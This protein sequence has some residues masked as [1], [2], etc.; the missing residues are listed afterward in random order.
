MI[1]REQNGRRYP[2][3]EY[4]KHKGYLWPA[5]DRFCWPVVFNTVSD[6]E[7]AIALTPGRKVAVQAGGNCGVWANEL[8]KSFET[9]YTFEPDP[10]N[11]HCLE[12][13]IVDNVV[14]YNVG[15]G[16]SD[17]RAGMG[18]DAKEARNLGALYV[19]PEGDGVDIVAL[20]HFLPFEHLDYVCLDIEGFEMQALEGMRG[21]LEK[22]HPVLQL[23]D[24]GLSEKYG[25]K[26]GD[27]EEWLADEFGYTV[28]YRV[29][30][31]IILT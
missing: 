29:A 23:E 11:F 21:L 26:K 15:L 10:R 27:V 31:D 6:M 19:D 16:R 13:N 8:A 4:V 20:D 25:S 1:G 3:S 7:P 14:A 9:V 12:H 2:M 30:R 28:R 18:L 5:E 17:Y 22:F 24:K